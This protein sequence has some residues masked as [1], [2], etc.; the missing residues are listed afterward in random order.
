VH[1]VQ[2]GEP[3]PSRAEDYRDG[4]RMVAEPVSAF[5]YTNYGFSTLGQIVEDVRGTP[6]ERYLRE[7]NFDP[8]GMAGSD[9][10][11]SER[12]ASRLATGGDP[13]TP[14]EGGELRVSALPPSGLDRALGV[15][16]AGPVRLTEIDQSTGLSEVPGVTLPTRPETV[17]PSP[18]PPPLRGDPTAVRAAVEVGAVAEAQAR[19]S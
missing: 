18:N 10:A 9:H 17:M 7:R 1:S 4:L 15:R 8:L 2:V 11:R 14:L 13:L 12:I 16:A 3:L 19:G 6:F 5:A